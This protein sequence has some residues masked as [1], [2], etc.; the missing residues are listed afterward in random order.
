MIDYVVVPAADIYGLANE[1]RYLKRSINE[2][3][4]GLSSAYTALDLFNKV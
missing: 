2:F 3:L 4:T 1:Y